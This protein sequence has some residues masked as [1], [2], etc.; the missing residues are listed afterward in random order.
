MKSKLI[1]SL[2][3]FV[4]I[5]AIQGCKTK[6]EKAAG[7]ALISAEQGAALAQFKLGKMYATGE[8]VA[9]DKIYAYMWVDSADSQGL[10]ST[11]TEY[12]SEL[13]KQM[14]AEQIDVAKNLLVECKEKGFKSC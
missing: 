14:T 13:E 7:K 1:I 5:L 8:G 9:E 10:G 6:A 3:L 2:V 4:L 12:K 11:A